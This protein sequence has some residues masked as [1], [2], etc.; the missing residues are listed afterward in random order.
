MIRHY[1]RKKFS[2]SLIQEADLIVNIRTLL[3]VVM[4]LGLVPSSY[5]VLTIRI[6]GGAEGA[7]PIAIVPFGREDRIADLPVNVSDVITNNFERTGRF[8]PLSIDALPSQPHQSAQ[9]DF[10]EW[11]ALGINHLIIG[12][13]VKEGSE[14]FKVEFRVYDVLRTRTLVG[15]HISTRRSGLRRTAHRISDIIYEALTGERGAFDTRIA[16]VTETR[17][18]NNNPLYALQVA[19]SDGYAPQVLFKSPEPIISPNWSPDSKHLAYVSF[20]GGQPGIYRQSI[21][22][23]RRKKLTNFRGLNGAPAFSPDGRYLAMTLSKDGNPEIY[24]MDLENRRLRRLTNNTAIDTEPSWAPDGHSLV[25]TSDRSGGPQIYQVAADGKQSPKRITFEGKY[26]ARASFS[27]DGGGLVFVHR[28]G[29]GYHIGLLNIESDS[30][31]VLTETNLDESP[32]FSP[33]GIMILYAT[34][35]RKGQPALAAISADGRVRQRLTERGSGVRE[36][37]WSPFRDKI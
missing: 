25:F 35:D 13:I 24:I 20:E 27:P 33:N 36:P 9:I 37:A 28:T 17:D 30:I 23:K 32:S 5:A 10:S 15:F 8:S 3:V 19:D 14:R 22:T 31:R 11:R 26:N 18:Q 6:T 1:S 12:N 29:S 4:L 34:T 2:S 16:Y 7:Q 21:I